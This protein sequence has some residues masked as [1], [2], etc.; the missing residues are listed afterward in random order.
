MLLAPPLAK[1]ALAFGPPEKFSL[2]VLGLVVLSYLASGSMI[3][4]IIVAAFGIFLGNIGT[5]IITG[6]PKFTFGAYILLDG[7]GLIPV[8]MRLFGIGEVLFNIERSGG[9]RDI[10]KK[11]VSNLLPNLRDWM[12]SLGAIIRG[13]V[14][15]FFLGILP[16]GGATVSS[17]AAYAIEK[18]VSKHREKFGKGAIAG[19]AA[20]ETANN[21]AT[22]GCFIPLLTLGIPSNVVMALLMRALL[23]NGIQVGPL[24]IKEHPDLF[25]GAVV[26]MYIGNVMLLILNLPLIPVWV[27][28]LK[29]PYSILFPLILLFCLIGVY[30]LNNS[31]VEIFIMIFFS[32]VG[33]LMRKFDFE[34]APLVMALIISPFLE[35][36]LRSSLLMSQVNF[37]IFFTRPIS[38]ILMLVSLLLMLS[39]FVPR[40]KRK[41]IKE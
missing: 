8:V 22:G 34:P 35:N 37:L 3:K 5:D 38:G 21:S 19:V 11:T 29:V 4:A 32:G 17:F 40:F 14:I 18:K 41:P 1:F 27:Q 31:V 33:Y 23:I 13:T 2:M 30:S 9:Q 12:D 6:K 7:V 24:L 15:G 28:I 20:P 36:S 39:N 16:G 25:W 10:F 26:S